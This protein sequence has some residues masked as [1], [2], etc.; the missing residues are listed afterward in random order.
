MVTAMT[1]CTGTPAFLWLLCMTYCCFILNHLLHTQL[2]GYCPFEA[3]FGVT[4][5]ISVLLIFI[6]YQ[7]VRYLDPTPHGFPA[8]KEKSG[9]FVGIAENIGDALTF[10]ILMD[11]TNEI[12]A[13]SD[14][15]PFD[16]VSDPNVRTASGSSLSPSVDG[17]S[18]L[19]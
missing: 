17:E 16:D 13:L 4:P 1:D 7:H 19:K 6:W 9:C 14:V 2:N 15:C 18:M 10:Y 11:T 12:I 5:G 8:P 3:A